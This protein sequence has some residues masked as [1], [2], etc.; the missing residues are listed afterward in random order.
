[1]LSYEA[2]RERLLAAVRELESERVGLEDACGRV[3][4]ESVVA[5]SPLPPFA[6]SAM[7]GYAVATRDL[8]GAGPWELRVEGESRTGRPSVPL[9]PGAASAISTGAEVPAGADAVLP[10]EI[11]ERTSDAIRFGDRVRAG[12]HVRHAGEDLATG[13]VALERGLRLGP[14]ALG[15]AASLDVTELR[16]ARRPRVTI[17]C[18]GDELRAPGS[19]PILGKIPESV[20][21]ALAALARLAGALVRRELPVADEQGATERAIAAALVDTD[22]LLTVGG[23]SV[24][25]HDWVR[26]ALATAGVT[27]DFWKVAIKPGKPIAFGYGAGG[28]PAVLGLPGNPAS[29]LITFSLFGMPLLRAMQ[30]DRQPSP[31][32]V[33]LPLSAPLRHKT[34]RLEF[35]RVALER[36]D[37]RLCVLPLDNQAS[38]ALTSLA[39]A[40]GLALVPAE[41]ETLPEGALVE[42]LRAQDL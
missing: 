3:L 21:P 11:V 30:G 41:V 33:T 35:V 16:V 34:G 32:P 28:S 25:E 8:G 23:V 31:L 7:D 1:M 15:L 38:G 13:A 10:R 22:V 39:W 37:G 20:S 14:A 26:P 4:A 27:L 29:A 5:S 24:G 19:A 2:A 9:V 42:V 12:Q 18:T 36:R 17:L 40:A 6:Y